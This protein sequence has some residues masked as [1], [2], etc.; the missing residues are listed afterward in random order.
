MQASHLRAYWRLS[1]RTKEPLIYRHD[2]RFRV[3]T[4]RR[5]AL[6]CTLLDEVNLCGLM[7]EPLTGRA[8]QIGAFLV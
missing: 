5:C 6:Q 8:D 1:G 4:S 7:F 3:R 2:Q